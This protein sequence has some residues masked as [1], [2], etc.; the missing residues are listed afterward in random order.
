MAV[1][2]RHKMA[3]VECRWVIGR[4]NGGAR[5]SINFMGEGICDQII[6]EKAGKLVKDKH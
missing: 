3:E 2:R 1:N 6:S 5:E 4:Q